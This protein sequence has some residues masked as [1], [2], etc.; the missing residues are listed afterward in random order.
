MKHIRNRNGFALVEAIVVGVIGVILAG[1]FIAFMHVHNDALNEGAAQGK[2]QMHSDLV[3]TEIAHI[4]RSASHV[5]ASPDS[6]VNSG[7]GIVLYRSTS[8]GD[9]VVGA[10]SVDGSGRLKE[11]PKFMVSGGDTIRVASGT[12]FIVSP[13]RKEVTLSL[14]YVMKSQN[15]NDTI[16]AKKDMYSCRN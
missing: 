7:T 6:S 8:T 11:G 5:V 4:V 10:Y 16:P 14:T 2:M 12:A 15:R 13:T 1:A 3:S 9:S